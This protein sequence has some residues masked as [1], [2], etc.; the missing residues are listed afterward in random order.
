MRPMVAC[1]ALAAL[2]ACSAS[3]GD[4]SSGQP[5]ATAGSA[6]EQ[7]DAP[8]DPTI[9]D[10][11]EA[12]QKLA[13]YV[14][15]SMTFDNGPPENCMSGLM[16]DQRVRICKVCTVALRFVQSRTFP[17]SDDLFVDRNIFDI[18]FKRAVSYDQENI[19]PAD[20]TSG[21]WVLV[22]PQNSPYEAPH[23]TWNRAESVMLDDADL[24]LVGLAH[25]T[26]GYGERLIGPKGQNSAFHQDALFPYFN[27]PGGRATAIRNL[28]TDCSGPAGV[29]A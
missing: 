20:N 13:T 12:V 23:V 17:V 18:A 8:P 16:G 22:L 11:T 7:A 24:E 6:V 9:A 25:W 10:A 2:A 21:V 15:G 14:N 4:T 29:G 28:T 26:D 3:N 1:F 27:D 5:G 19:S